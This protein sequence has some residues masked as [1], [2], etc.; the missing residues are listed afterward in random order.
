M[1]SLICPKKL[2]VV[3]PTLA[4]PLRRG[5]GLAFWGFVHWPFPLLGENHVLDLV[6]YHTPRY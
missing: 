1:V 3:H 2:E 5:L 4:L 6:A